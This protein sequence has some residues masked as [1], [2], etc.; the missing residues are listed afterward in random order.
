M[1]NVKANDVINVLGMHKDS[2]LPSRFYFGSV[3]SY[4]LENGYCPIAAYERTLDNMVKFPY[5]D[6]K[7][8]WC[9]PDAPMLTSEYREL[10]EVVGT[11]NLGDMV[12]LEG[13][14]FKLEAA[15]NNNI[16]LVEVNLSAQNNTAA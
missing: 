15:A 9:S 14:I 2:E 1:L 4:A 7:T 10:P 12:K 16:N 5:N 11:L 3:V 8:H 13:R 6:H